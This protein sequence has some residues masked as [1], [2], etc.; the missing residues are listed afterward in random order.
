MGQFQWLDGWPV[1]YTNWAKGYPIGSN[2]VLND[3][4]IMTHEGWRN[5]NCY[6]NAHPTVCKITTA[7]QP[8]PPD[9]PSGDCRKGW[10]AVDDRCFFFDTQNTEV[11]YLEALIMCQQRGANVFPASSLSSEVNTFLQSNARAVLDVNSIWL[12]LSY[13]DGEFQWN[14]GSLYSYTNWASEH[15]TLP[16]ESNACVQL[17][18]EGSGQWRNIDCF[19]K[20]GYVC[21]AP[22]DNPPSTMEAP[23]TT[24]SKK[25]TTSS[26]P[27]PPEP[28]TL[29]MEAIIGISVGCGAVLLI[30]LMSA[31]CYFR[32]KSH[33]KQKMYAKERQNQYKQEI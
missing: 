28:Y 25:P 5:V 21:V 8:P 12:G 16:I 23:K 30:I 13:Q 20:A 14:D 7:P 33:M 6:S 19:I 1:Q 2:D 18:T 17:S 11:S 31:C 24:S 27:I 3:C 22:Y 26:K 29:S 32:E 15:P 9:P 10:V 4:V